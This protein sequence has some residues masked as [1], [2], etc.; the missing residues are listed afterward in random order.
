M[1]ILSFPNAPAVRWLGGRRIL[2]TTCTVCLMVPLWTSCS[3]PPDAPDAPQEKT[4]N[5]PLV[6]IEEP[7]DTAT[8]ARHLT[9]LSIDD[10]RA[11]NQI[12]ERTL[13][14]YFS[15]QPGSLHAQV[16]YYIPTSDEGPPEVQL[17][18]PVELPF[19]T[20]PQ[21]ALDYEKLR[22]E[23]KEAITYIRLRVEGKEYRVIDSLVLISPSGVII[24]EP[25]DDIAIVPTVIEIQ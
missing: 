22:S 23:L 11:I 9:D 8:A 16:L 25:L 12:C 2:A 20:V 18:I 6:Q 19:I 10:I 14:E 21:G 3:A 4:P 15:V 13:L 5:T 1:Y 7:Q 17:Q 24:T